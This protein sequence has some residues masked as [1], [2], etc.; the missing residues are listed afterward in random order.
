LTTRFFDVA[1]FTVLTPL[2][3]LSLCN[4]IPNCQ[5]EIIFSPHF[6]IK[7]SYIIFIWYL[8]N[9]RKPALIPKLSFDSSIFS[10]LGACTFKTMILPPT[11]SQNYKRQPRTYQLYNT[12]ILPVVLLWCETWSLTQREECRLRVF[13]NR[14]LTR[15][16][17]PKRDKVAGEW[18]KLCN[19]ELNDMY[20]SPNSV[21][22]NKLKMRRVGHVEHIG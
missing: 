9:Y 7:I 13:E 14:V 19:E 20:S 21:H 16:F 1:K 12:I 18:R 8:K 17:G 15:I 3:L 5:F 4:L 22:V 2:S 10:S 11:T 6:C